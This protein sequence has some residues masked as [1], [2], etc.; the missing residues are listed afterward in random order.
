[1]SR[2]IWPKCGAR[3]QRKVPKVRHDCHRCHRAQAHFG[4]CECRCG[5]RDLPQGRQV[6][7]SEEGSR[8]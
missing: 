6:E 4:P 3:W 8:P 7:A 2:G 5:L 1:M